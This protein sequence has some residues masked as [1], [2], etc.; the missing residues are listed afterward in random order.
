MAHWLTD[1]AWLQ[2]AWRPIRKWKPVTR[3]Q[4]LGN[5]TYCRM[6]LPLFTTKAGQNILSS[7][8]NVN[9]NFFE[10]KILCVTENVKS[11]AVSSTTGTLVTFWLNRSITNMSH[12][13]L[14]ARVQDRQRK[15]SCSD[16]LFARR[17]CNPIQIA[18]QRFP[19]GYIFDWQCKLSRLYIVGIQRECSWL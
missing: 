2:A 17:M 11:I 14:K 12:Y 5:S 8:R 13:K 4:K 1:E 9:I 6:R 18:K 16:K 19:T 7:I 10:V 15:F 3:I